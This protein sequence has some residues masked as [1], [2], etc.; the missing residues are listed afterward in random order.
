MRKR[1]SVL[2]STFLYL[3]C[4]LLILPV[5]WIGA[6]I[7]AAL[8]HEVGH[9]VVLK[10]FRIPIL[11]IRIGIIGTVIETGAMLP[12]QEIFCALAGPLA[13]IALAAVARSMPMLLFCALGQTA[14]NLLPFPRSDGG[15]VLRCI[16]QNIIPERQ[17]RG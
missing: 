17:L 4:L 5:Q 1:I 14:F 6:M 12:K 8:F 16:L 10:L 15:R 9:L 2:P 13:G 11:H 7:T 3:A